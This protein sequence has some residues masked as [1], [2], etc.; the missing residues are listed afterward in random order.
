VIL[1]LPPL[2]RA[3]A[4]EQFNSRYVETLITRFGYR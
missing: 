3:M 1:R 4:S 2:K